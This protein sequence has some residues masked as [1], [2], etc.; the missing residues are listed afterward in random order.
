MNNFVAWIKA[1]IESI[2]ER[3]RLIEEGKVQFHQSG[4]GSPQKDVTGEALADNRRKLAELEEMLVGLR[5]KD[6]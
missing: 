6:D 2:K 3:V 1:E 5:A 4:P